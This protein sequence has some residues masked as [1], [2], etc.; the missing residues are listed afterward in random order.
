MRTAAGGR[1]GLGGRVWTVLLIAL[2]VAVTCSACTVSHAMRPVLPEGG[3]AGVEADGDL[4]LLAG[5]RVLTEEVQAD[6]EVPVGLGLLELQPQGLLDVRTR[7]GVALLP[8][9]HGS[10]EQV[11]DRA[12]GRQAD[13]L[14]ED[15]RGLVEA[16]GEVQ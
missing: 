14:E 1:I 13:Q 4:Q 5:S 7:L 10:H 2:L 8:G 12:L 11:A 16:L 6:G 9:Q 3:V 15:A